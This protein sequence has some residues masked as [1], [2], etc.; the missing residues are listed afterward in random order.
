MS[1]H[2]ADPRLA[3]GRRP[4]GNLKD[5]AARFI[6]DAIVSGALPPH[7]KIDQ[8]QVADTLGISR[9]PVR[10]ALIELAQKGFVDAIPRR[11]AFVAAVTVEDIEDHYEVVALVSAMTAKR[12]VKRLTPAQIDELRRLDQEIA[13]TT[14]LTRVRDLDRRFFH[15]IAN[16]GRSPR[17]DTILRFLGGA[18]QGSFYFDAPG[19]APHEATYREQMLGAI[20]AG[21][22][23]AAARISEEHVRRCAT[24]AVDHLRS[25]GYW[26]DAA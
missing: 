8:D 26:P 7:S 1:T 12:A 20:D 17:L 4:Y 18:L 9:A 25:R 5:E 14:D 11:G 15:L 10:E 6:R 19:W 13:A 21:D 22:V 2:D 23:L 16:A 3:S 24:L